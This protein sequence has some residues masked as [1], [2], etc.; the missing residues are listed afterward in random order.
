MKQPTAAY[1]DAWPSSSCFCLTPNQHHGLA[2]H[3]GGVRS[4]CTM[5]G[6]AHAGSGHPQRQ[7]QRRRPSPG[8]ALHG[9]SIS[10]RP[11]SG[12]A[13]S[14]PGSCAAHSQTASPHSWK[15]AVGPGKAG[16]QTSWPSS[17]TTCSYGQSR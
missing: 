2:T 16:L 11:C 9:K 10:Q 8:A 14:F 1:R 17:S 4:L 12:A 7:M 5:A 3:L 15:A 13:G 6:S